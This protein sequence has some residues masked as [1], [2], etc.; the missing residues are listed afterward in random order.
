MEFLVVRARR[1]IRKPP[2]TFLI[3]WILTN[4]CARARALMFPLVA[5]VCYQPHRE[6][7]RQLFDSS[8]VVAFYLLKIKKKEGTEK[9]TANLMWQVSDNSYVWKKL[10]H[11]IVI[12]LWTDILICKRPGRSN[13]KWRSRKNGQ[14]TV[15]SWLSH[16]NVLPSPCV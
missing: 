3:G 10:F 13:D 8:Q 16:T 7:G 15:L 14:V 4:V 6:T 1:V 2:T 12:F 9:K 11:Q 5:C